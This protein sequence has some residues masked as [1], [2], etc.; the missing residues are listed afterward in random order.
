[1][2]KIYLKNIIDFIDKV[3]KVQ[4]E[5]LNYEDKLQLNKLVINLLMRLIL[6]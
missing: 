1:M 6:N 3:K 4:K 5:L 2:K